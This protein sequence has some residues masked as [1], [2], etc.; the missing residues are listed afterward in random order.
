MR[1]GRKLP[2][3]LDAGRNFREPQAGCWF[4]LGCE[5]QKENTVGCSFLAFLIEFKPDFELLL[6]VAKLARP[7]ATVF[8]IVYPSNNNESA[9]VLSKFINWFWG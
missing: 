5:S 3:S 1:R 8:S 6:N 4:K 9:F 2:V 7:L